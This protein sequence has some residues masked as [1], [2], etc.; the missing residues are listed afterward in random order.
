MNESVVTNFDWPA[1][2]K[3]TDAVAAPEHL[4][5]KFNA[6]EIARQFPVKVLNNLYRNIDYVSFKFTKNKFYNKKNSLF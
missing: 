6:K 5:A 2:L 3:K 4:F 1:Y